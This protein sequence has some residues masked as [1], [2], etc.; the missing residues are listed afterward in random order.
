MRATFRAATRMSMWVGDPVDRRGAEFWHTTPDERVFTGINNIQW[1]GDHVIFSVTVPSDEWDRWFS[2]PLAGPSTAE[3]T[4]LTTTDG[5]IEDA[6]SSSLSKDGKTFYYTTN[7]GDIDR[8]HIWA[9]PTAGG[10]PKQVSTGKGIETYPDGVR[11]RHRGSRRSPPML[12][13]RSPSG[14]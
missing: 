1:A 13:V 7:A 2:L 4:L 9:V 3:P 11:V 14:S 10:T 6:T 12:A 8:R 5:I